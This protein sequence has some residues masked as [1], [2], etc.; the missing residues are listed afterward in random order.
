VIEGYCVLV[1]GKDHVIVVDG[2]RYPFEDH[3]QL[4]P[5]PLTKRGA[6]RRLGPRHRFW[7]AATLW[8]EQG[9]RLDASGVCVWD[10]PPNPFAGMVHL[11]GRHWATP[12]VAARLGFGEK[13]KEP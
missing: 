9:R 7:L 3:P 6:E 10:P 11:G 4:G 13:A 5:C 8:I 12:A 2:E 1:G